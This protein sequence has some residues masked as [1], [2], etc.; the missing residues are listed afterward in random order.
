MSFAALFLLVFAAVHFRL[1][2]VELVI[3]VAGYVGFASLDKWYRRRE[4]A[5]IIEEELFQWKADKEDADFEYRGNLS[6]RRLTG[7][8]QII[9]ARVIQTLE[10]L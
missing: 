6:R 3:L 2:A 9:A 5:K 4:R 10:R 1:S 8:N 7:E